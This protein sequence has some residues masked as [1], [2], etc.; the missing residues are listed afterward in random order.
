VFLHQHL[1]M[2]NDMQ[3]VRRVRF[4]GHV[5]RKETSSSVTPQNRRFFVY[6]VNLLEAQQRPGGVKIGSAFNQQSE[7][8]GTNVL[9]AHQAASITRRADLFMMRPGDLRRAGRFFRLR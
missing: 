9:L 3:A 5:W 2:T 8:R 6:L 1:K 7:K 4:P